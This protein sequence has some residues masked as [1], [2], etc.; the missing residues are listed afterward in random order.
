VCL[1]FQIKT[2]QK[3]AQCEQDQREREC[4]FF[5]SEKKQL[6]LQVESVFSPNF[7]VA[8]IRRDPPSV[9]QSFI[10]IVSRHNDLHSKVHTKH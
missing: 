4:V 5:S 2:F 3:V 1:T 7:S 10:S 6:T 9:K 8:T